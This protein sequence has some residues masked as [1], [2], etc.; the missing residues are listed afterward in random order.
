MRGA[1]AV[2]SVHHES[3]LCQCRA[4]TALQLLCRQC[5][6]CGE[7]QYARS[8]LTVPTMPGQT[9]H[10]LS[11][12]LGQA[13]HNPAEPRPAQQMHAQGPHPGAASQRCQMRSTILF[14]ARLGLLLERMR[15]RRAVV[16]LLVVLEIIISLVTAGNPVAHS[17]RAALLLTWRVPPSANRSAAVKWVRHQWFVRPAE[18]QVLD[19]DGA[20]V[21]DETW[22]RSVWAVTPRSTFTVTIADTADHAGLV[23]LQTGTAYFP[24]CAALVPELIIINTALCSFCPAPSATSLLYICRTRSWHCRQVQLFLCFYAC[25]SI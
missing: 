25:I 21:T 20:A 18:V 10:R 3:V 14:V 6:V 24:A 19:A 11:A 7:V 23:T 5:S 17:S 15:E 12:V 16:L 4:D 1:L 8:A 22:T 9:M 13:A 2:Y